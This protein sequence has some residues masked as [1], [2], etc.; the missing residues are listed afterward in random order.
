MGTEKE[1][2]YSKEE[3]III[4]RVGEFWWLCGKHRQEFVDLM[5]EYGNLMYNEAITDASTR[6]HP[7]VKSELH[8]SFAYNVRKAILKLLKQ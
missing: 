2:E 4:K 3:A 6:V 7:N 5:R 8:D 1:R